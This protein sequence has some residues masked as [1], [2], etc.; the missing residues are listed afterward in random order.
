MASPVRIWA[1]RAKRVEIVVAGQRIPA[2]P[3]RDGYWVGPALAIGTDYKIS[4]DGGMELP[5]PRTR[6]QP[7]GVHG[8]SRV[9]E[10][11]PP[12]GPAYDFVAKPLHDAVIYEMH[13]GTFSEGG[14][15]ASAARHLD[16][17][18]TL[19]VTHVE[20]LPIAAFPGRHGWGYDGVDLFAVHDPYGGPAG[21]HAFV[22]ACHQ[23][24]LAVLID[25]VH[26][27]V[28]PDGN[29]LDQLGPYHSDRHQTPWG[30]GINFDAEGSR[31]VRRFFIDSALA[32]L[33]DYGADGLRLDAL[34][35]IK[36]D[37]EVHFVTQLADEVRAL[38]RELGREL[39]L[40][41]EWDEHDPWVV[42]DRSRG[43]AGLHAHWND[44]FHHAVHALLTGEH[45]GYYQDFA[46]PDTLER[47]L[48]NGYALD[49]RMSPF[50]KKAHGKPFGDLPRDRLVAY[51]QSH[52]QVGNRGAGERLVHLAG[53]EKARLAAAFLFASPFVPML[54]QGEEWAASTPFCYFCDLTSPELREAVRKGRREEHAGSGWA[55]EPIDPID[56]ATRDRST[57]NWSEVDRSPH[58]EM[59][60]WY[61]RW[62]DLRRELPALRAASPEDT[63]VARQGSILRV[64]RRDLVLVANLSDAP[65]ATRLGEDV[66][67]ASPG[68]A[69]DRLPPWGCAL[70]R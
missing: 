44:D 59:L 37:S 60:A 16:H 49:G 66:L 31:E 18:V 51:T 30:P 57:L 65:A 10:P 52:D 63:R 1:P 47:I 7:D 25:V 3:D 19:G 33:R 20:I 6:W 58:A 26:N 22:R 5:D 53:M 45:D 40:I 39:V 69:R 54:F 4:A 43:G 35:S 23:R 21:L 12:E 24:G 9:V 64:E 8:P 48:R 62:I 27:H 68:V 34:H 67:I 46:A 50:R 13:I 29:Y 61:R 70:I 15:F 41:G 56:P 55:S 28:G 32:W 17:L 42:A 14:T 2:A 38:S 36:D 11:V